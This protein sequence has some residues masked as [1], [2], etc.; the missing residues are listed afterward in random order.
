MP[1][2]D[3]NDWGDSIFLAISTALNNLLAAI[4]AIVGALLLLII[5]WV[6]S[7]VADRLVTTL[8]QR[9]GADRLLAE[10]GPEVYGQAATRFTPSEVSG[11]VVKWVIRLLFLIAAANLVGLT[12]ISLLLNQII[13]W[14]PN[15]VVAAVVLLVAPLFAKFVRG[16]IEVG[17]G[18][19]GFTNAPLLGRVSEIA[20]IAFA[21]I[22][23]INQ[24]GIAGNLVQTLF[25]GLVFAVAI[26]F[27]LAFGLGGQTVAAEIT[28]SWYESSRQTARRVAENVQV[29]PM[30]SSTTP[31]QPAPR[32]A[33]TGAGP[34]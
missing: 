10:R 31:T 21:V 8:L 9:A 34:R 25:N 26:A 7:N 27:G 24:I 12:E 32:P 14:L 13:L 18:R 28:R 20:I 2:V 22:I 4:P 23:A 11:D 5:G 19:M 6:L 16:A 15:L 33:E 30:E 3:I 29:E 1:T 17:A